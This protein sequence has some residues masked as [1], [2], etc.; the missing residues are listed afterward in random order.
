MHCK[1]VVMLNNKLYLPHTAGGRLLRIYKT[2]V[3][4]IGLV[5]GPLIFAFVVMSPIEGLSFEA[6]V[7]LGAAL[8]MSAWWVTEA[9]PLYATSLLPLVIFP[10]FNV[11]GVGD[12][13]AR[14]ADRIV[15]LFLG[16]LLLAKSIEKSGLHKRFALSTLKV[17]GTNPKT[18]VAAFMVVTAFLS[19]WMSNTATAM[20]MVP[21]AAAV[22]S[23]VASEKQRS[24]FAVCLMLSIAYAASLGGMATLVGTPPNAIFASLAGSLADTD[25]TFW[26]WMMVG[27]PLSAVSVF[28]V[29]LYLVNVGA[30][31]E[32]F[33]IAESKE[34][35]VAKLKELGNMTRDEKIVAAVF[36]ATATAWVTR[37]LLWGDLLPV[38][39]DTWIVILAAIALFVLPSS[40][41]GEPSRGLQGL[42]DW[43]SASKIPWGVLLLMGGG[44]ALAAA[45][46]ATGVDEW[47][48]NRL[49]FLEGAHPLVVLFAI[50][51]VT[52]FA[53]EIISNTATAALMIPISASLAST[54][55]MDPII[56][57]AAVA[58]ATSYGFMMPVGTPPNTIVFAT[59][60]VTVSKM[61]RAG[62]VLDLIGVLL[63]AA[64]VMFLMPI[65]WNLG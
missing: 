27:F 59:G 31:I 35:I 34:L 29:W 18:I 26:Q 62:V 54:L 19:A 15:F 8:W 22:I 1:V 12:V 6:K 11:L 14:Y 3:Q 23:Q 32:Q 36:A 64:L 20:L 7:V 57:M 50:V 61:A 44:L 55:S 39:D 63:V 16:G 56:L 65:A 40:Q 48:A 49:L 42:L 37:G 17:V 41:K 53:S 28:I 45:F 9:I 51:A 46:T 24:R 33:P 38:V 30:K 4:K 25:V 10:L 21:I 2:R 58:M 13:A 5:A 60:Y 47:I 52:I 43:D